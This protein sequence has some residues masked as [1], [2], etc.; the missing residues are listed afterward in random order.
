MIN[1]IW[2]LLVLGI[3]SL[4]L[5]AQT[6]VSTPLKDHQSYFAGLVEK[7]K[8]YCVLANQFFN[9]EKLDKTTMN[10]DHWKDK[11]ESQMIVCSDVNILSRNPIIGRFAGRIKE[12]R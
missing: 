4:H 3:G 2:F 5:K 9:E 6:Y 10:H 7:R 11:A 12:K 1:K 8:G